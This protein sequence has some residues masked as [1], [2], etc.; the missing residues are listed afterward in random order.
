MSRIG[1]LKRSLKATILSFYILGV[2]SL[3]KVEEGEMG[4]GAGSHHPWDA[5][6][7]DPGDL[8]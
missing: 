8:S 6:R 5:Y 4:D 2:R 1:V 7:G 3:K